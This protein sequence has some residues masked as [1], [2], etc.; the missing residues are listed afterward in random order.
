MSA[1][2]KTESTSSACMTP[3]GD[4]PPDQKAR[5][6][7]R[8]IR[9]RVRDERNAVRDIALG[10]ARMRK[11]NLYRE[12]G[13]AGL[14]EY[15]EQAFGFARAK[16]HQLAALGDKLA[17]L[18]HLD[19]AL[20]TGKLGWTKARTISQVATPETDEVWVAKAEAVSSRELEELVWDSREGEPPKEPDDELDWPRNVWATMRMESHNYELLMR[21]LARVRRQ[22]GDPDLSICQLLLELAERELARQEPDEAEAPSQAENGERSNYRIVEH[23]CP[24][25]DAAW[26]DTAS[27]KQ[28]MTPQA[29]ELVEC[30]APVI[31]ADADAANHGHI[32]RTIP[33]ATRRAVIARD[34][35]RCQV[36]GC[37]N[38]RF[39]DLHHIEP[40]S[41]GGGHDMD[42]LITV[43]TTHHDLLHRDVIRVSR[44]EDGELVWDR[45]AGEPLGVVLAVDGDRAEIGHEYLASFEDQEGSL[46]QQN[47]PRKADPSLHVYPPGTPPSRK[48][49]RGSIVFRPGDDYHPA[50]FRQ[51][52]FIGGRRR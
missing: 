45:G 48:F 17:R 25:C 3:P 23:R 13:Y 15:G 1:S 35:G 5:A 11:D 28:E 12:L 41:C 24:K 47:G 27:G 22:L 26:I 19:Q 31:T 43:C 21:A 20:R 32:S 9:R 30:D 16:T 14:A 52:Q 8:A 46:D 4:L 39:I 7:H 2:T 44:G 40:R 38:H 29:R 10:L 51:R 42:N 6:L 49:P 18:P 37:C 50:P 34:S 33:P 36:P